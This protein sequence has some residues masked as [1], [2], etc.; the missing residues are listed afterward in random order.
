[1]AKALK[2]TAAA[3]KALKSTKTK[4]VAERKYKEFDLD[5]FDFSNIFNYKAYTTVDDAIE[6]LKTIIKEIK[7]KNPEYYYFW[8]DIDTVYDYHDESSHVVIKGRRPETDE[9]MNARI[10]R[11]KTASAA[12][13]KAATKRSQNKTQKAEETLRALKK[14][15][16]DLF[17]QISK[18]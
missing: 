17:T 11:S 13:K 7:T 9:E 4:P 12:A 1:M 8:F 5:T 16:S 15:H 2:M 6:K 10:T 3:L 14:S 18:E